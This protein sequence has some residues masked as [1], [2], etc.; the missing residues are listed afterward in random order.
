MHKAVGLRLVQLCYRIEHDR[1][2]RIV[3]EILLWIG[4]HITILSEPILLY[5]DEKRVI[6]P[7]DRKKDKDL[8]SN[9]KIDYQIDTNI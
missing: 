7:N 4:R 5:R 1:I 9:I 3:R 8:L 6:L 2:A